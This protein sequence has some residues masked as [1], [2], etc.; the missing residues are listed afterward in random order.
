MP[1]LAV[2]RLSSALPVA[3]MSPLPVRVMFS[4]LA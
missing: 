4:M 1:A 3:S 2:I